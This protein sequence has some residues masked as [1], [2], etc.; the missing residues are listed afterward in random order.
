MS[1]VYGLLGV[2]AFLVL[3]VAGLCFLPYTPRSGL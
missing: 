3:I 1:L 2:L